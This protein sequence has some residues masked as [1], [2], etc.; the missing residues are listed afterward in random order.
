M[1]RYILIAL[2][3]LLPVQSARAQPAELSWDRLK[4]FHAGDKIQVVDQ[5][6]RSQNGTFVAYSDDAITYRIDQ[7]AVT[8]QRHD[9]YRISS[10]K[11]MSR[12]KH[13]LIGLGIGAAWGLAFGMGGCAEIVDASNCSGSD[14][15]AVGATLGSVFGGVGAG[16]GALKPTDRP[17]IYRAERRQTQAAP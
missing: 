11:S 6:L 2:S 16:F 1:T 14:R 9:V 10:L 17:V 5:D 8:T 12:A 4:V 13:A 7:D 3:L 15:V